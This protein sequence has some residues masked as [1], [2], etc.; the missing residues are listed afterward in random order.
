MG[1]DGGG[2]DGN[3]GSLVMA[4]WVSHVCGEMQGLMKEMGDSEV[5]MAKWVHTCVGKGW[6]G[7]PLV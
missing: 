6:G 3:A 7:P 4:K 1:G 2:G 5:A